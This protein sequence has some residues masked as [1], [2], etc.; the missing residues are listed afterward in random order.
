MMLR[1]IEHLGEHV[2]AVLCS[3]RDVQ[4]ELLTTLSLAVNNTGKIIAPQ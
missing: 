3:A 2:G 4:T 1:S